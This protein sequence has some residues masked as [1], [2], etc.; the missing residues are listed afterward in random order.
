[1]PL[2]SSDGACRRA[3][4]ST[5][6]LQIG[7]GFAKPKLWGSLLSRSELQPSALDERISASCG[8]PE[9]HRCRRRAR[10]ASA[11][12]VARCGL[13]AAA[14][15]PLP[16][17]PKAMMLGLQPKSLRH[18]S[19]WTP[20]PPPHAAVGEAMAEATA[21]RAPRTGCWAASQHAAAA[22]CGHGAFPPRRG[23]GRRLA[24]GGG[25]PRPKRRGRRGAA[26][27]TPPGAPLGCAASRTCTCSTCHGTRRRGHPPG[28]AMP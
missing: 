22:A 9:P 15:P 4:N 16:Q 28:S 27:P 17:G 23:A 8:R 12:R 26:A 3:A 19:P 14:A 2:L 7:R 24:P 13:P 1:M 25:R 20:Q 6:L 11:P 10:P 5:G 18:P 21:T